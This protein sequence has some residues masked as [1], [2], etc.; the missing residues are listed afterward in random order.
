M[1]NELLSK[2]KT[3]ET[4]NN[5]IFSIQYNDNTKYI[6][7]ILRKRWHIIEK[8]PTLPI[9]WP[10]QPIVAYQKNNNLKD[11]LVNAKLT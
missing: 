2:N 9:L 7:Q 11:K 10:E 3:R 5:S 8:D 4:K 6:T 1:Q